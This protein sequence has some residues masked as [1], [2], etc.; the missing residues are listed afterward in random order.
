M[1]KAAERRAFPSL[2]T[3]SNSSEERLLAASLAE[4]PSMMS[5]TYEPRWAAP[6]LATVLPTDLA[7][8]RTVR[9]NDERMLPKPSPLWPPLMK[10]EPL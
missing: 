9:T 2:F 5:A 8:G 3:A 1:L 7:M 10:G 6:C 4:A